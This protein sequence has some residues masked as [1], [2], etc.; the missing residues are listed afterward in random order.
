MRFAHFSDI[1]IGGWR[2]EKLK[3]MS[4]Q[5][6]NQ[7]AD[8]IIKEQLD[9]VLIA[10]DLFDSALP[11]IDLIRDAAA[12]LKKLNNADIPIYLIPG[13]HDFS[14]SGKTMIE[15]LEK[16]G[17]CINVFKHHQGN[18]T[19]TVDKKTGTKLTGILGLACGLDRKLY[20]QLQKT[21]L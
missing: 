13:S 2:E 14:P 18:L 7:A 19:F 4:V 6:L 16:A 1:H 5:A 17:L 12:V 8:I 21:P 9:F 15:V 20:E 11:Q 10:G 3:T